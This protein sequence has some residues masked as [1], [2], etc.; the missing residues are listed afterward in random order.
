[1]SPIE[2]YIDGKFA[3]RSSSGPSEIKLPDPP[4]GKVEWYGDGSGFGQSITGA[5]NQ[6]DVFELNEPGQETEPLKI[7]KDLS[8]ALF[9][10]A[11]NTT[12]E[13]IVKRI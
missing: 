5:N 9:K 6:L 3:G 13:I 7:A 10:E 2:V 12:C 11:E 4:G 1:M 8:A